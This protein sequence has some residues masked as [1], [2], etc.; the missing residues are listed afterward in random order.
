MAL[1]LL[2]KGTMAEATNSATKHNIPWSVM[3]GRTHASVESVI[4]VSD[5][6]RDNVVAWFNEPPGKAP[7]PVGT[8]LHYS[9]L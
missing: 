7:Y 5:Q 3:V 9:E 4:H 8:L 1:S 6:F 2:V